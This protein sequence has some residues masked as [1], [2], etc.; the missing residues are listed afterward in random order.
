MSVVG[1]A[2]GTLVFSIK[3]C[4][5]TGAKGPLYTESRLGFNSELESSCACV[6]NA[7]GVRT[8]AF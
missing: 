4:Y 6:V 2:A 5:T 3:R 8:P 7:S 1:F